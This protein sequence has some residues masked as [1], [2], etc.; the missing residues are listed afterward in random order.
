M[1]IIAS[2]PLLSGGL[3]FSDPL[4]SAPLKVYLMA[5]Q[6]NMQGFCSVPVTA[7][8]KGKEVK[9]ERST[10][11]V[12]SFKTEAGGSYTLAPDGV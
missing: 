4:S 11:G 3:L 1:N 12:L 6:S 5:D 9:V 7:T 8:S 10:D 2:A